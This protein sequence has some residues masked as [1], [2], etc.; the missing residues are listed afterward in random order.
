MRTEKQ[1]TLINVKELNSIVIQ[2]PD[3]QTQNR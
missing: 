1:E 2:E 3:T